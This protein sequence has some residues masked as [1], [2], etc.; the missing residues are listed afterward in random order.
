[1]FHV[2]ND[3]SLD[4]WKRQIGLILDGHGVINFIVH[5]DYVI[6]ERARATYR[7]LLEYLVEVSVSRNVWRTLPGE[8]NDWWRKRSNMWLVRKN[9]QWEIAGEGKE[10]ARVAYASWDGAQLQYRLESNPSLSTEPRTGGT[11]RV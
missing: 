2:L 1:M 6:Q 10:R 9:S 7:A 8:L 5:P 3:Y 4:H 11:E